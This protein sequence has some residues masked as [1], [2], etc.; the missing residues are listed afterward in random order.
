MDDSDWPMLAV[1]LN[2]WEA[3]KVAEILMNLAAL[4]DADDPDGL[5]DAYAQRADQHLLTDTQFVM[6]RH[7]AYRSDERA[8]VA[9]YLRRISASVEGQLPDEAPEV[10]RRYDG[11]R[12]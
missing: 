6:L 7:P 12:H 10:G 11:P 4:I 2:A 3:S 8:E 5:R 9:S 1:K